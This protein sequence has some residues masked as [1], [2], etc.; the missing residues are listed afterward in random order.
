MLQAVSHCAAA[1]GNDAIVCSRRHREAT[2]FGGQRNLTCRPVNN[3]LACRQERPFPKEVAMLQATIIDQDI[4]SVSLPV[5]GRT[6]LRIPEIA[7]R[8]SN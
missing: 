2:S 4:Q 1:R 7:D 3:G 8:R 6:P 5:L